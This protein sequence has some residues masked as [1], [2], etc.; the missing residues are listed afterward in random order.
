[1]SLLVGAGA[2]VYIEFNNRT[3]ANSSEEINQMIN[4]IKVEKGDIKTVVE[5]AGRVY[6]TDENNPNSTIISVSV[7]QYDISKLQVN[8]KVEIKSK[9]FPEDIVKGVITEVSNMSRG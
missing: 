5:A 7:N 3:Q 9:A 6:L 8:Q 1:M 2:Y 4:L